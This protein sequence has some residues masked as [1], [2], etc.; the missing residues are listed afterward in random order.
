MLR[1]YEVLEKKTK[2]ARILTGKYINENICEIKV[3]ATDPQLTF[4]L[5]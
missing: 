4:Q 1:D 5:A 2:E 3:Q